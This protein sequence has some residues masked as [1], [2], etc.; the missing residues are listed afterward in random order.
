M[1]KNIL[2][3]SFAILIWGC[4]KNET[5]KN[6]A[7]PKRLTSVSIRN[8][9]YRLRLTDS[10]LYDNKNGM[11]ECRSMAYDTFTNSGGFITGT[12]FHQNNYVFSYS[13]P[14]TLPS[15]YIMTFSYSNDSY[16]HVLT[17]NNLNQLIKD[18]D[19]QHINTIY[20]S[21]APNA[22]VTK[23]PIIPGASQTRIDSAILQNGNIVSHYYIFPSDTTSNSVDQLS[24][25]NLPNPLYDFKGM[26]GLLKAIFSPDF[27]W[28]SRNL[29][30]SASN[31]RSAGITSMSWVTDTHGN[32]VS[33]TGFTANGLVIQIKFSYN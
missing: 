10:F 15:S 17:Y 7:S 24:Y 30:T 13:G 16:Q 4:K 33:G 23:S 8:M 19:L 22:I 18:S 27:D 21:Y 32:V 20:L 29:Y 11:A 6:V 12:A 14:D 5:T 3:L 26:G 9:T 28:I 25:S 2:I 1:T 31:S